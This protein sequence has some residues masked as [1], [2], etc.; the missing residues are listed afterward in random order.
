MFKLNSVFAHASLATAL[1]LIVPA[2]AH[3]QA[4]GL[5]VF[6]PSLKTIP[7]PVPTTIN[8]Y[9]ADRDAAIR[10]GKAL[11]WDVRLGSDGVT[12]CATCHHQAGA[13][14][15]VTNMMHPG[16]NS[17]FSSGV[18]PGDK[19]PA[20]IF[21]TT[22]FSNPANRFSTRLRN[23]DDVVGSEGVM[24]ENFLGLNPDQT[25]A[26]QD[27]PEPVF[28]ANGQAFAQVTGRNTPSVVNAIYN[29]RQFWDGRANA[30]FNGANPFGPVDPTARVWRISPQTQQPVQVQINID[31]ASLASQAVGPVNNDV[32]MAAHG[33]GWVDVARKLLPTKALATQKVSP[34]DSVLGAFAAAD[35]GLTLRYD[36]MVQ[37][38]FHAQWRAGVEVAPG[39]T[40]LQANMPLFFGLA[41]QMYESTLVSNDSRYDQWIERDGP[42][43]GA[44]GV[45]TPRE[46]RGLRL[47]FNLDPTLPQTNCR[48]CHLSSLFS[49]ATYAGK[50]GGGGGQNGAGAFPGAVDSDHDGYPDIIDAF[51][52]DPTEWLDTDHDH[53]GNNAD[54]DDDNDGLP[55]AIDPFPLDP[56]NLPEGNGTGGNLAYAPQPIAYMPDL[57]G[58][59]RRTMAFEEPPLGFEPSVRQMDFTLTG[60]GIRVYDPIGKLAV[61][62]PLLPRGMFPCNFRFAPAVSV[63]HLGPSAALMVDATT[64]NCRMM[65]SISLLNFPL[66]AYRVTIDGVDRGYL[67]SDPL[68]MYDEGFYNIGV[69]PTTEDLG[70]GGTHP[71]GT[72]LAASRRLYERSFLPEFG[73]LWNGGNLIPRV[74]GS[75]KTPSLRN[76]ELTA[77]YFHNGGVS[78]LEDV[79]RFY[80]R[81]GDFHTANRVDL[82]PAMLAMDLDESHIA[83]LA[84]FLRTLTDERVRDERAPF[85]HPAM[86]FPNGGQLAAIGREG[87][88]GSCAPAIRTFTDNLAIADPWAGDCD[89][90]GLL[91]ACELATNAANVD[92]NGNGLLDACEHPACNSDITG[93]GMVSGDDLAILLASWGAAG[94]KAGVADIDRSGLVDGGD[95]ALLL[96]GWGACP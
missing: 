68:V 59:L 7:A 17:A 62:V 96:G 89:R 78:T 44:V 24:R 60:D 12:A 41:V 49:A 35:K 43:G 92:R 18:I 55:D 25:E 6:E 93:D 79:I 15:R 11:F 67:Y 33:R 22:R 20:S 3:A 70:V 90:N 64:R 27:L 40:M 31:H 56:L 10:L 51:P 75:F 4:D 81:G 29:V 85:D 82:A 71:N 32:E 46:L 76:V 34:T 74:N 2:F 48:V 13:D 88:V 16:A 80:N 63:P 14:P 38:A 91:D 28:T 8:D 69:R 58:M 37:A 42:N 66:G 39:V 77:P 72:P 36:E 57:A 21:P 54:P 53:I 84:A 45:L 47:W 83:D 73:Q 9:V 26:C 50:I 19:V 1:S 23:I 30:W 87:R 61:H 52:L 94:A 5:S 95:L 65:L 86:P